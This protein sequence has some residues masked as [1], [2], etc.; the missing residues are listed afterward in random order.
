MPMTDAN[1]NSSGIKLLTIEDAESLKIE[2]VW[3]LY[4]NYVNAPQTNVFRAFSYGKDLFT[5]SEGM[6]LYTKDGRKIL[7]FTGGLGVLSH[8]HNN[9]RILTA[10]KKFQENKRMEVHK[11]VFSPYIAALSYNIAQLL[12]GDLNISYFPNS[13]AEAVEGAIKAAYKSHKQKRKYIL[14]ADISYHGKLI[15]SGSVSGS[16]QHQWNFPRMENT[17]TFEYGNIAS[18]EELVNKL[19]CSDGTSDIYTIIVEPFNASHMVESGEGFLRSLRKLCDREGIALIFDEVY[20]G[21]GKSGTLFYFMRFEGLVPDALCMSKS[22]GGG[23]ASISAYVL[24][25][26]LFKAAYGTD[27]DALL[28]STTYNGFGEECVTAIEAV[29]IM[30]EEDFPGKSQNIFNYLK[31]KLDQ[32]KEKYPKQI[33]EIRGVG[34]LMGLKLK[35]PYEFVEQALAKLPIKFIENKT[36]FINKITAAA[37]VEELYRTHGILMTITP[38]K[39]GMIA[40]SP[41]IIAQKEDM[42]YFINSLEA[43]LQKGLTSLINQFVAST[44]KK[45]I[46]D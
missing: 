14:H 37:M 46:F 40:V 42:D 12:P 26:P 2:E 16:I 6:Y 10:R 18:V 23:K 3:D 44:L 43:A 24:R 34:T 20:S 31:P 28:H 21:W 38:V 15:G 29:R 5:H 30:I 27:N 45:M 25:T 11:L 8:G 41:S 39:Q 36:E 17:V 1:L 33:S 9:P 13:G 22:F 7:D 35:S 19:R 32:L 4:R